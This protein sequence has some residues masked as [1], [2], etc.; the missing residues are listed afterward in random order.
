MNGTSK[1]PVADLPKGIKD[2]KMELPLGAVVVAAAVLGLILLATGV[3]HTLLLFLLIACAFLAGAALAPQLRGFLGTS[4]GAIPGEAP[5][6][7]LLNAEL[8]LEIQP[9]EDGYYELTTTYSHTVALEDK[10]GEQLLD[11]FGTTRTRRLTLSEVW[12]LID[13][14]ERL[15]R[16]PAPSVQALQGNDQKRLTFSANKQIPMDRSASGG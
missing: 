7:P 14:I 9:A 12:E 13:A 11:R 8:L 4:D 10:A 2:H 3:L 6:Q 16:G 15:N 1:V 5:P